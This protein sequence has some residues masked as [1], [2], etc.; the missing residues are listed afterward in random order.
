[1]D[2]R[3][4]IYVQTNAGAGTITVK[5]KGIYAN[6]GHTNYAGYFITGV[7]GAGDYLEIR[8]GGSLAG[9]TDCDRAS[10]GNG[11]ATNT[12]T[13]TVTGSI[14]GFLKDPLWYAAKYGGFEDK[15]ANNT[16]DLQT[17]WD[18]DGNGVPD[19]YFYAANPLQLETQLANAFA[20]ILNRASSGTAAS[21][22][23]SSSTG[24]GALYQSFFFPTQF[25]GVREVKWTGYTQ[26][27]FIDGFGNL[28]EDSNGDGRLVY[29]EDNIVVNSFDSAT[30]NVL[31]KRFIDAN[32]DGKADSTTPTATVGLTEVKGMWEAGSRLAQTA[33]SARNLWTW[34]DQDGDGIVDSGEFI[35][36]TTSN[37][38]KIGPY[39]RTSAAPYTA[40]NIINFIRGDQI[41]GLRDRQLM[42]GGTLQVW[43]LGD[44][45]HATP[46]IVGGPKERHDVI[47]GDST[48]TAFY[49]QYK[50]RRQVAYLGANDGMLHAINVGFYHRGDDPSTPAA[51][52][53]EH[54]WFTRNPTD[55]SSGKFLG[56]ELW[57][58][59]PQE[60]LP[61][62]RWLAQP[63]YTHVYYVDLKPKITDARIFAPDADHPNGWG[64]ILIGGFRMGG[65]CESCPA[66]NGRRMRFSADFD[67][68]P[69]TP[70]ETRN[71]YSAYFVLD[72]TNPE[73]NPKLLWVFSD[74][75]QGFT[76]SYPAIIR[77]N[78]SGD[79]KTDN[80]NA[81]WF[82]VFGS[83]PTGYDG[84]IVQSAKL[85]AV[86]LSTGPGTG[87]S[88]VTTLPVGTWNS[89]M[90]D[91]VTL[92]KDLDYRTDVAYAGR[93]I[94]DG[95]PPWKG[96]MY[97]LTTGGCGSAP[98]TTST[99]GINSGSNRVPTEIIDTFAGSTEV[100]PITAAPAITLDDS[101]K[102]WLF[103]GTGRYYNTADK[104]N[105]ETQ[106]FFGIKDSVVGGSC[107]QTSTTSCLDDDLVN[108]SAAI[109]CTV[110]T[111]NQV[112]GVTGVTTLEGT[113]TS[114]LQGL[115]QTKD[116][117]YT[118][119]PNSRERAITN[120]TILGGIVFF[121]T[122]VPVD[123]LCVASGDGYLYALFYLTGSAYK[124]SVIGTS[125]SGG[126]TNV[127]RSVSL[128]TGTGLASQMAI[129]IGS[130]GSG[131][132]GSGG[133]GG[134]CQS[135]V[136][137]YIQSSTGTLSS[138]C[139]KVGGVSSRYISW[140]NQRL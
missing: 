48:Y 39:L 132:A 37:S 102:I 65:S 56:E 128:G 138:Y 135:G 71:F 43:K 58:F 101:G 122:F 30:G 92:D 18:K 113:T 94:N 86:N 110:C 81:E 61:H 88:L 52:Q 57:G 84:S 83:G 111:G 10:D 13:F 32:G 35:P 93:V 131:G 45:I 105:T 104:T 15:N 40:N 116:G 7:S 3:Y 77:V 27:L 74:A 64:T 112:S 44:P 117:W 59:I 139:T 120:P 98:C 125:T 136:T 2:I 62:L 60:L 28:R 108:V 140:N 21:V 50:D 126:N 9:S 51:S 80:T 29:Q 99:W 66:T 19:T 68:D 36:F 137:G 38:A 91:L 25:E 70:D 72:I 17:E 55:N 11:T 22:L 26:G 106:Y 49:Q 133:G 12:R 47:Y 14:T 53:V 130:Q 5:T 54:G 118:T 46:V 31:V 95:S 79:V 96:K 129:Q 34:A 82:V 23:A 76:T 8:C 69:V 121:P 103:F 114:S 20:A 134:G 41:A 24:E 1:M 123:D 127:N 107:T 42:V 16:P 67:N 63:D 124:E 87:N 33:S 100:G 75:G 109:I 4:R 78:P 6:S 119:L 85:Y 73:V 89:W 115:V 97:R 90:G